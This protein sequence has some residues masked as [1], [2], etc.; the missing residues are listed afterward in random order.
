[1][2]ALWVVFLKRSN[3]GSLR[4]SA[5]GIIACFECSII[6]T[7]LCKFCRVRGGLKTFTMLCYV[8]RVERPRFKFVT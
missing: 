6:K 8:G 1:M 2:G 5:G 3:V 7:F 4:I